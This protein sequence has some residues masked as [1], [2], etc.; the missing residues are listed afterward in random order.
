MPEPS[1]QIQPAGGQG[2]Q[3]L[4]AINELGAILKQNMRED[5]TISEKDAEKNAKDFVEK[6][7]GFAQEAGAPKLSDNAKGAMVDLVKK[8]PEEMIAIMETAK[9]LAQNPNDPA[10]QKKMQEQMSDLMKKDP[11]A[12]G[13]LALEMADDNVGAMDVKAKA[14]IKFLKIIPGGDW[15]AG[16]MAQKAM[17]MSAGQS[18][19]PPDQK[20]AQGAGQALAANGASNTSKVSADTQLHP[21]PTPKVGDGQAK[22]AAIGA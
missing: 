4:Q 18:L 9:Q 6:A 5:G 12:A 15:L 20:Q 17:E 7:N 14:A 13:K 2:N 21:S 8:H 10:A 3:E 16:K 11:S 19:G 1:T 22:G